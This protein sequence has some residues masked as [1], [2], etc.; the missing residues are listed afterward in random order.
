MPNDDPGFSVRSLGNG[1]DYVI[2][3][4]WQMGR[5]TNSAVLLRPKKRLVGLR[6]TGR[7]GCEIVSE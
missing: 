6:K 3:V 7:F 4:L 2:D 5:L 1:V